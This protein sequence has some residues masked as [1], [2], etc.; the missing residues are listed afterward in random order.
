[1][2]PKT[3]ALH[4]DM[5]AVSEWPLPSLVSL[6]CLNDHHPWP[7]FFRRNMARLNYLHLSN[8]TWLAMALQ[9]LLDASSQSEHLLLTVFSMNHTLSQPGMSFE[10]LKERVSH[11][12]PQFDFSAASSSLPGH[13]STLG[14]SDYLGVLVRVITLKPGGSNSHR[15]DITTEETPHEVG[16]FMLDVDDHI[17]RFEEADDG[18]LMD[19]DDEDYCYSTG[20]S[21]SDDDHWT[22]QSTDYSSS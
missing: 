6:T 17:H 20:D 22:D 16:E 18:G 21:T 9:D 2:F 13:G 11:F 5:N 10:V 1:M 4:V 19:P 14:R 15:A 8:F 12:P 3:A 7:S